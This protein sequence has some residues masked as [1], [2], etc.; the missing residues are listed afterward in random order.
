MLIYIS[1]RQAFSYQILSMRHT[2]TGEMGIQ[3]PYI[4]ILDIEIRGAQWPGG[5]CASA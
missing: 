2:E 4:I 1:Y 5:Q 3:S